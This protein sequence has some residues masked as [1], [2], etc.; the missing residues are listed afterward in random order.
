[1]GS[2][3]VS[4]QDVLADANCNLAQQRAVLKALFD[5][6]KRGL[7]FKCKDG[8]KAYIRA[9]AEAKRD[10]VWPQNPAAFAEQPAAAPEAVTREQEAN[11]DATSE[12]QAH[13]TDPVP[14]AQPGEAPAA[15]GAVEE[16]ASRQASDENTAVPTPVHQSGDF[17]ARL[18]CTVLAQDWLHAQLTQRKHNQSTS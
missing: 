15:V 1:M 14:A 7:G 13:A 9:M 17:T 12:Q 10:P 3:S 5:A 11:A 6:R 4:F 16:S 2:A 18:A 8:F